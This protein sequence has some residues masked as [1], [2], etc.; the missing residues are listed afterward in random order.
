VVVAALQGLLALL[1]LLL[2]VLLLCIVA[3]NC[4]VDHRVVDLFLPAV[5]LGARSLEG[6]A[7]LVFPDKIARLPFFAD[8]EWVVG[9]EM[10]LAP[11]VLPVVR[12]YTLGFVVFVV[13]RAPLGLE[14]EHKKLLVPRHLVN[15]G[16]LDVLV[17]MCEGA[18][19]FV[20]AAGDRLGA[21]LSLVF[22]NVVESLHF[23]VDVLAVDVGA[24]LEGT[25]VHAIVVHCGAATLIE[26]SVVVRAI[27]WVVRLWV[28]TLDHFESLQIQMLYPVLIGLKETQLLRLIFGL[29]R[30]RGLLGCLLRCGLLLGA[31]GGLFGEDLFH[32]LHVRSFLLL[33]HVDFLKEFLRLMSVWRLAL[34]H[35]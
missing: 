33:E 1:E 2:G 10:R 18:E 7:F 20:L 9:K 4:L 34:C 3:E 14:V 13:E 6:T 12:V 29:S 32:A 23:V 11:E 31:F 24:V 8:F 17:G 35:D 26:L 15:E 19:L 30:L 27:L 21:K 22:L 25:E 16:R 28:L 5:V